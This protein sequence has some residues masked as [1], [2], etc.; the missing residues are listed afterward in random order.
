[1]VLCKREFYSSCLASGLYISKMSRAYI[2]DRC[3]KPMHVYTCRPTRIEIYYVARAQL[4]SFRSATTALFIPYVLY[5][6]KSS[7][8]RVFVHRV[9]NSGHGPGG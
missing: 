3:E 6:N 1:M 4:V 5:G 2:T 7:S 9:T 8:V